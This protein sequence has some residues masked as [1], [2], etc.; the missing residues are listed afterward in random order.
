ML[1]KRRG[2]NE[3]VHQLYVDFKNACDSVRK[4]VL[5]SISIVFGV[6]VK[7]V[8]LIKMCFNE[9]YIKQTIFHSLCFKGFSL[10]RF[11]Y[12]YVTVGN[13]SENI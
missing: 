10:C 2:Y 9:T 11:Y 7:L 4:E 1:E 5:Y 6:P 13:Y 3:A 8:R 12:M